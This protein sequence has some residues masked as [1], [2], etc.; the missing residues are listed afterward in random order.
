MIYV[1]ETAPY[2]RKAFTV[3]H[4]LGHY[5]LHHD[6]PREVFYRMNLSDTDDKDGYLE[7]EAN[8]F[9]ASLLMPEAFVRQIWVV[10]RDLP[11]VARRC[12]VSAVATR[13]RL[14]NLGCIE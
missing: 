9:A 8:W 2:V 10:T 1:E 5:R 7:Q 6:L 13:Y 12:A 14:K 3:A 11:E 4:E